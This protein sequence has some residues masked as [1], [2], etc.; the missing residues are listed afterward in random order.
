MSIVYISQSQQKG[1]TPDVYAEP[2][3]PQMQKQ[4]FV[5]QNCW[6][7]LWKRDFLFLPTLGNIAVVVQ[8]I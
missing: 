3:A 4:I 8:F 7:T 2:T 1:Q 5:A 6:G